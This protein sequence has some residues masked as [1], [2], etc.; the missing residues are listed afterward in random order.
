MTQRAIGLDIGTH[1]VR[2]AEL[3]LGRNGAV[4]VNRFGQ[5]A[6]PAGA[7]RGGE[8]IDPAQVASAIKR[9][10]KEVGYTSR[11]VIVGVGNQRV[12]VRPAEMSAMGEE[13]LRAAVR[14]QASELIPMPLDEVVLDYQVLERFVDADG[15]DVMRVLIVAA[16]RDMLRNLLSAVE[17][18]GLTPTL[19]D[20][21]PFSLLR[22]LADVTGFEDLESGHR[23]AEAIVAVGAG[24]TT[25]VVH[26]RG[27]PKFVRM[28]MRGGE[29]LTGHLAKGLSV[30]FE[31]AE[32]LKRQVA[33][34]YEDEFTASAAESL[35]TAVD[36]FALEINKSLDFHINQPGSAPITRIVLTGG[37]GRVGGLAERLA[38]ATGIGVTAGAPFS[39][40]E[41]CKT[42]L[43]EVQLREAEDLAAVA[44]GLG[45]AGRP[46][47]RG[48]KRLSLL[49]PE[50]KAKHQTRQQAVLVGAGVALVVG[51]LMFMWWQRKGSIEDVR[52]AT[53]VIEA[54]SADLRVEINELAPFQEIESEFSQ[55]SI[56]VGS[57]LATDVAWS[58]LIQEVA[59]VLPDDVWL[60]TF[61]GYAET[62]GQPGGFSV[63]ARGVNHTS[64]ARWLLRLDNLESVGGLWVPSS[65][66]RENEIGQDEATFSSTAGLTEAALS[67]RIDRYLNR[68]LPGAPE[69]DPALSAPTPET[70][71]NG[72][73]ETEPD[74]ATD[75]AGAE[76]DS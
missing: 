16:Q 11:K 55:R 18:A 33:L 76:V 60:D 73:F 69:G 47:D 6:L 66:I 72:A 53:A 75:A 58:K 4:T 26:E 7:V 68:I 29:A 31:M 71:D 34:G 24:V 67:G 12:V 40:L 8:I 59:T 1:A 37:G 13:D 61:T 2:A 43:S 64:S 44:V 21:V 45:L 10:W 65:V 36:D 28:V 35:Q 9:L 49:P 38:V 57:A 25:V 56:V 3:K 70:G 48:A 14:L 23:T 15:A 19:V 50:V 27:I 63:T 62:V 32:G 42:G 74:A 54:E 17:L 20:L 30:D 51:G 39:R 5:V 52:T 41:L 22:S 46:V